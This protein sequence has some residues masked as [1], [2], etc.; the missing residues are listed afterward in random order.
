[1]TY[2]RIGI[3]NKSEEITP[4]NTYKVKNV[5]KHKHYKS[6]SEYHDIALLET[7]REWVPFFI[8]IIFL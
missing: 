2:V 8:F 5:Y 4:F 6:P 3:L 7:D 1:M